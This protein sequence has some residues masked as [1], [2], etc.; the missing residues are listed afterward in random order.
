MSKPISLVINLQGHLLI[1]IGSTLSSQHN[2]TL[3]YPVCG[4]VV[5]FSCFQSD[6]IC[7]CKTI[8]NVFYRQRTTF[9]LCLFMHIYSFSFFSIFLFCFRVNHL[10]VSHPYVAILRFMSQVY[11]AIQKWEEVK[12][13]SDFS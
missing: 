8:P 4:G 9:C 11:H 6:Q 7:I 10:D 1:K 3:F 13:T 12:G 5:P 2:R